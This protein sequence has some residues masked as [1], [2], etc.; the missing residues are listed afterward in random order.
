MRFPGDR[1]RNNRSAPPIAA[2]VADSGEIAV[3]GDELQLLVEPVGERIEF[4]FGFRQRTACAARRLAGDGA[5]NVEQ[6]ADFIERF[7]GDGRAIGFVD[8]KELRRTGPSTPL[9]EQ[10]GLASLSR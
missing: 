5:L 8:V 10:A 3:A 4:G 7:L 6:G 9:G 1:Q 2:R